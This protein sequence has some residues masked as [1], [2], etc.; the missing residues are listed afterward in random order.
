MLDARFFPP[1]PLV[2]EPPRG[3]ELLRA[4]RVNALRLWPEDVYERDVRILPLMGRSMMLLNAPDA[5]NR[6]LVE[7]DANYRRT[8]MRVRLL[9]PVAG[10]GLLLSEGHV[11]RHQRRTAAPAFTPRGIP[12]LVRHVAEAVQE[13]LATLAAEP[14][15]TVDLFETMQRWAAEIAGRSMF[16][17]EMR[18]YGP[19][20]RTLARAYVERYARPY[21]LDV[22]LPPSIPTPRDV[23]RW[24]FSRRWMRLI[25]RMIADRLAAVDANAP[26][27]LLDLLRAARDPETN[28]GFTP[29]Q[30]RDQVATMLVAGHETT[31]IA[32]FWSLYLLASVPNAQERL[33]EEVRDLDLSPDGFAAALP[34][35]VYTKA[36][37]SEVLRLYPP[38]FWIV[39]EA[40]GADRCG[41]VDVPAGTTVMISPWV[42]GRHARYWDDPHAFDPARFLPGAPPVPRYAYLPFGIGPRICIGAQFAMPMVMLTVA[43]LVQRFRIT[44]ESTDPVYPVC[45]ITTRPSYAPQFSLRPR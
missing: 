31:S 27:D 12:L 3:V 17:L 7:N 8:P 24:W 20:M 4:L 29:R 16:S 9:R 25:E 38:A 18:T 23:R 14:G 43:G 35:L 1:R 39:R 41:T 10:N 37:L 40:I 44:L 28:R 2:K 21:L 22:L 32:A 33:A 45:V 15:P 30:L 42:L 34:R 36:V 19:E 26:R 13:G 6:V 5:I 11:W